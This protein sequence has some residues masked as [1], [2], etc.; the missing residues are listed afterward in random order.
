MK[1]IFV[2]LFSLL[3]Y[4]AVAQ[5]RGGFE[6]KQPR[7]STKG[8][9]I[10]GFETIDGSKNNT[11][12]FRIPKSITY[13]DIKQFGQTHVTRDTIN[14][15]IFIENLEPP[16]A[17]QQLRVSTNALAFAFVEK[18]KSLLQLKKPTEELTVL[19]TSTDESGTTHLLLEQRHRN[20]PIYG[21]EVRVHVKDNRVTSLNGRTFKTPTISV[22]PTFD[23]IKALELALKDLAQFT[24]IETEPSNQIGE[25]PL[26]K[27]SVNLLI[28][29]VKDKPTLSYEL[30][31]RPNM[32]ERWMYFIDATTGQILDKFNHT[33][34]LDGVFKTTARDLNGRNQEIRIYERNGTYF[35]L[36]ASQVMFSAEKSTL[37]NEPVGAVWTIDAKNSRIN[38]KMEFAHVTSSDGLAW[39]PTAV[40]AHHNAGLCYQY[41]RTTH[42]RNSLNGGGGNIISVINIADEDGTG[43]D[44]AYWNGE[45]MGYGNGNQGFKPLAG[46]LDVAGHEMTHGVIENTARLEYRN[47][48]GALNESFADIFGVLIDRDDWTL[49]E[50]IVKPGAFPSGA[51]RSLKDPNQGGKS[52]RDRGFQ[53]KNMSQYAFL[54]DT[55]DEDNGGVHINSGIPNHAFYLF[56]SN[57]G[58]GLERAEKVYYQVIS[59]YLT[60]T[61]NFIDLRL[62]VVDASQ[63]LYGATVANAARQAFDAVGI[64]Q[65][66]SNPQQPSQPK[67]LP[68]NPGAESLVIYDP[69]EE[70][71]YAGVFGQNNFVRI[72]TSYGCL[73]KPSVTD[74][75]SFVYFVAKDQNIYRKDLRANTTPQQLSDNGSFRNAAI[76]KDGKRLAALA[77]QADDYIYIF[78]L[79]NNRNVRFKLYNSTYTQGISTDEVLFADS[80]EWDYSG[81]FLIYDA[82][83]RVESL[84]GDLE[85]WDVGIMQ[86]WNPAGNAF[87]SGTI[88]KVFTNLERGDNIGNP[89]LAK[90]SSSV[91]A[92]DYYNANDDSYFIV[93][94]DFNTGELKG[95]VQNN[96]IGYPDYAKADDK[97]VFNSV[98]NSASIVR[99]INI[100]QDKISP[101]G[102]ATTLFTDAKWAVWYAQG[103]R[104]LPTKSAQTISFSAIADQQPRAQI[105]LNATSNSGL[106]VQFSIPSGD[107]TINGNRLTLGSTPGKVTVEAFQIGNEAFTAA[108]AEQT[109]CVRPP[110]PSVTTSGTTIIAAGGPVFQWYINGNPIGGQT[111]N[112]SIE[113]EFAGTYTVRT[114]TADGCISEA[115]SGIAFQQLLSVENTSPATF[116]MYP[117]PTQNFLELNVPN[118]WG[119][120]RVKCFDVSGREQFSE[121]FENKP[122]YVGK[123]APGT[124]ILQLV[125][126]EQTVSQQFVKY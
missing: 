25:S 32:M 33:C 82:F 38:G 87:G 10:K 62:A 99:G 19:Q 88:E 93:A 46:S 76:S 8:E 96:D 95:I 79:E 17:G 2:C 4:S 47:Q 58:V 6:K 86:A 28:Y 110:T 121:V 41:F 16:V 126:G 91:I 51:L 66:S 63:N 72:A 105:T 15:V 65:E 13:D 122:I 12:S 57:S 104:Q 59:N 97:L 106:P 61:S 67:P 24:N 53:P 84:F 120:T 113:V 56:A 78:D 23:G 90:T 89:A 34:T 44:N 5:Q 77:A 49:G 30:T 55:P 108:K 22:N 37:P 111:T 36:D 3:M 124:Y 21:G 92:F 7:P 123:L 74:N 112:P 71:L 18:N 40:S 69:E 118:G 26:Q 9:A 85:Y 50:D 43:L 98:E 81:E 117:N 35:M 54:R 109:F 103:Q 70:T 114:I 14:R 94:T 64:V 125:F 100:G 20:I 29:Y 102:T 68:V 27:N 75:G 80:F 52:L 101:A 73:S 11:S 107:A 60:R 48:S 115:S 116:S 39:S 42:G 83:N 1:T 31:V 45:F 119:I